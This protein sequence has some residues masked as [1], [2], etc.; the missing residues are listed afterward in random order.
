MRCHACLRPGPW[1]LAGGLLPQC[2]GCDAAA[3][4]SKAPAPHD[5]TERESPRRRTR[6]WRSARSVLTR[7]CTVAL[8]VAP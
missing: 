3:P 8:A 5:S 1:R 6:T 2:P 4:S 7:S